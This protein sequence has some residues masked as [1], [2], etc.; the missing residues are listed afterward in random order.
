MG[1]LKSI[2]GER[3]YCLYDKGEKYNGTRKEIAAVV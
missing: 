3:V 2:N 1:K